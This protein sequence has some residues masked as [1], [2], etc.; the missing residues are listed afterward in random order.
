MTRKDFQ[1]VATVVATIDDQKTRNEV[2]LNFVSE[3]NKQ[4]ERFD[5]IRFLSACKVSNEPQATVSRDED[6][7]LSRE[8]FIAP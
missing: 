8:K 3:L 5:T 7:H 1:L 2:A 4:N 6:Y